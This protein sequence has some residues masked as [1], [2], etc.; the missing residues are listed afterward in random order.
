MCVCVCERERERE[1]KQ[2]ETI[3]AYKNEH[4]FEFPTSLL[5]FSFFRKKD[6]HSVYIS[7]SYNCNSCNPSTK[8]LSTLSKPINRILLHAQAGCLSRQPWPC[9]L[10]GRVHGKWVTAPHADKHRLW[11]AVNPVTLCQGL[12]AVDLRE[13]NL[14]SLRERPL[15][16]STS[17]NSDVSGLNSHSL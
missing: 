2:N 9:V 16:R 15:F 17:K 4:M 12:S 6:P 10:W 11:R 8:E 14:I 1:R 3:V 5:N 13:E 7:Y